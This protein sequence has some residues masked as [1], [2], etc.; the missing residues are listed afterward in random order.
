MHS[1]EAFFARA[2][3]RIDI[4]A[5]PDVVGE[6]RYVATVSIVD[7]ASHQLRPLI[8]RGGRRLTFPGS[9]DSGALTSALTYLE[10]RFG[11]FSEIMHGCVEPARSAIV[12]EPVV[13]EEV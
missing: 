7:D 11:S 3:C 1:Q 2:H 13:V 12:G 6:P 4:D 5:K 9:T 8:F 10:R